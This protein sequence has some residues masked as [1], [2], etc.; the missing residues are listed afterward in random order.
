MCEIE[1]AFGMI[2]FVKFRRILSQTALVLYCSTVSK[3]KEKFVII[4]R[5]IFNVND[6]LI[7]LHSFVLL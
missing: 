4:N 5:C 6:V 3:F 1:S 2:Q 7:E